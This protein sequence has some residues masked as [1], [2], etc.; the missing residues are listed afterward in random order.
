MGS[1]FWR[2]LGIS[3]IRREALHSLESLFC[4]LLFLAA[5]QGSLMGRMQL[6]SSQKL[7]CNAKGSGVMVKFE[8]I[9]KFAT[10][11]Q[12]VTGKYQVTGAGAGLANC[13][14]SQLAARLH[15]KKVSIGIRANILGFQ[16]LTF[17]TGKW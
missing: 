9:E 12:S 2:N 7:P 8:Q 6:S 11:T 5:L 17:N 13:A 10:K 3:R 15:A 4:T 1:S 16:S 14:V